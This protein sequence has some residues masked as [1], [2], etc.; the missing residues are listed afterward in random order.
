MIEIIKETDRSYRFQLKNTHGAT[1]LSSV[2]FSNK[3]EIKKTVSELTPLVHKPAVFERKTNYKGK[4]L[5]N[6]KNGN[7]KIIGN[8]PLF[9]SE[10]GM[11]NGIKYVKKRIVDLDIGS[12]TK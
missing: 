8:S 4:F 9:D 10:A 12:K 6:L 3:K 11:E 1:I 2:P 5:F 7:G